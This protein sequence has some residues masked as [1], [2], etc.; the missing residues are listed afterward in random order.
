MGLLKNV[1][2]LLTADL[3]HTLRNM[4]HGDK[5]L[6]CDCN[7]PAAKAA[8][9]STSGKHIVITADLPTVIDAVC[10]LLPLDLFDVHNAALYMTPQPDVKLPEAGRE[11]TE[12]AIKTIKKHCPGIG[13][14]PRDRF[15]FYEESNSCFA[16]VQTLERRP[17]GNVILQ[18]GVVGPDG[19][20]LRP[21][22]ESVNHM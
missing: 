21:V 4:G 17:Y 5:L 9:Q 10:T 12:A 1:P 3:L 8:K 18:K 14:G 6:I 11:V 2:P 19:K 15:Q 16:V 7:F 20:D 22:V 13:P